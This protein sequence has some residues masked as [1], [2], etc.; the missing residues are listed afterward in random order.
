MKLLTGHLPAAKMEARSHKSEGSSF[1]LLVP[2][3]LDRLFKLSR[4]TTNVAASVRRQRPR[5]LQKLSVNGK[6][7]LS[8]HMASHPALY[9]KRSSY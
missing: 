9:A 3:L 4:K 2:L 8:L 6:G 5:A 1:G 7:D